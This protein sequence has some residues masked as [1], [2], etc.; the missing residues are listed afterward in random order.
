M[1][2][3]SVDAPFVP[4]LRATRGGMVE[5][6][7]F[8][9]LAVVTP[10]GRLLAAWGDPQAVAFMRSSAKPFQ[11]LPLVESGALEAFEIDEAELAMVC[12]SHSG[13]DSHVKT[14]AGLQAKVGLA[15]SELQ[16]GIHPPYDSMTAAR[17]AAEAQPITANRNNCSGKHTGMLTLAKH[18][19]ADPNTYLSD[20]NPVQQLILQGLADVSGVAPGDIRVGIDGCSAP[21]FALPLRGA[22]HAYARLAD[23]SGLSPARKR[24]LE[25]I[26]EAMTGYPENVAGPGRLDTLLMQ[27][28]PGVLSKGGAEGFHALAIRPQAGVPEAIGV[29]IKVSDGDLGHRAMGPIVLATLRALGVTAAEALADTPPFGPSE[30]KNFRGLSVGRLETCMTWT[31]PRPAA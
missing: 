6:T 10:D 24:A 1:S 14:V 17:L 12:A 5:S 16:C 9:A 31:L 23:S 28:V 3:R 20:G 2:D 19:G 11:A 21:N 25:R 22:A 27:S 7:H 4:I 8:G 29:A 30:L 15:E 18:L 13:T 26:F